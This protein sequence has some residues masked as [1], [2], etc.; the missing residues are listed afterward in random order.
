MSNDNSLIEPPKDQKQQLQQCM[1]CADANDSLWVLVFILLIF[2][3]QNYAIVF[4]GLN[5]PDSELVNVWLKN[6]VGLFP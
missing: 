2:E 1:L 3:L 6:A 4:Y 5:F